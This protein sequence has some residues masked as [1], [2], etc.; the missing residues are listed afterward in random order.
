MKENV[1]SQIIKWR[2]FFSKKCTSLLA[3][4]KA[5]WT[6]QVEYHNQ[7]DT[8]AENKDEIGVLDGRPLFTTQLDAR[9]TSSG[10]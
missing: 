6:I 4:C 5:S 3:S 10:N 7:V 2:Y 8:F 9:Y 1:E